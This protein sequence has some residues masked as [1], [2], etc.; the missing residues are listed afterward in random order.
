[1]AGQCGLERLSANRG[2]LSPPRFARP[3][4]VANLAYFAAARHASNVPAWMR[5][6]FVMSRV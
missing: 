1:M 5:T 6:I 3:R 4:E 2:M